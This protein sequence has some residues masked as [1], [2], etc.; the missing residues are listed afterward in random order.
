MCPVLFGRVPNSTGL[1]NTYVISDVTTVGY[2]NTRCYGVFSKSV[3][4]D[5]GSIDGAGSI[6]KRYIETDV[7]FDASAENAIFSGTSFQSSALKA[8]ACIKT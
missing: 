4:T 3:V 2:L 1:F 7:K 5:P 6:G 8:L